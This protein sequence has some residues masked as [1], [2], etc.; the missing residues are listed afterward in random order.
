MDSF[1]NVFL[2]VATFT[3]A[4]SAIGGDTWSKEKSSFLKRLTPRGWVSV[5][6]ISIVLIFGCWKEVRSQES[7]LEQAKQFDIA[8]RDLA[9]AN[10]KLDLAQ[11]GLNEANEKLEANKTKME[12]IN[13]DSKRIRFLACKWEK[14]GGIGPC[15]PSPGNPD[16]L[17]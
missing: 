16:G 11:K 4:I 9:E 7:K 1:I 6:A 8:Q 3:T 14:S 12:N 15:A 2:L 13:L 10:Q 17:P 5:V